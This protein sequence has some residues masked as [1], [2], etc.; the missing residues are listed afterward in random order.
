MTLLEATRTP[1]YEAHETRQM[2]G[3]INEN[4]KTDFGEVM[5]DRDVL[6]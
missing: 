6:G 3:L 4:V 1:V 5:Q 2:S